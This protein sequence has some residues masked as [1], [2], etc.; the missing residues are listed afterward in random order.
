MVELCMIFWKNMMNDNLVNLAKCGLYNDTHLEY[1][2]GE[3]FGQF[4]QRHP[5]LKVV[6]SL[7]IC[8]GL[9]TRRRNTTKKNEKA[10]LDF[11]VVCSK[12]LN[13]ITRMVI[14]DNKYVLTNCSQVK[15]TGKSIS[16]EH[17]TTYMDL[18]IKCYSEKYPNN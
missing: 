13:Y 5:H 14:E 17:S 11:F 1:K 7:D 3:M 15:K 4:L 18:S 10:V 16:T 9:I 12:V 2:N 6:N 8:Q